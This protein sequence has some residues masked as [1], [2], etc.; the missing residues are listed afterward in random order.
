MK[1][2]RQEIFEALLTKM[3]LSPA[4]FE[5]LICLSSKL[6][7]ALSSKNSSQQLTLMPHK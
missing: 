6:I 2:H 3:F 1:V 7:N 4:M 5:N